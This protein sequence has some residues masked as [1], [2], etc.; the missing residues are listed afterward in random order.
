LYEVWVVCGPIFDSDIEKL[1]SGVEI[2]DA[3]YKII[4]DEKNGKVRALAFIMPQGVTTDEKNNL[5]K[6]LTSVDEIERQTGLDFLHELPDDVENRVEAEKAG[7]T[8]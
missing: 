7:T 8:W 2:P 6:F 5:G 1:A 3:Y 4:V